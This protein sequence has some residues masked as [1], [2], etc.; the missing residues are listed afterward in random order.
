MEQWILA[1]PEMREFIGGRVMVA[2]PEQWMDRVDA[3]KALQGWDETSSVHFR[4][5]GVFGEQILLSIRYGAWSASTNPNR[6]SN[7]AAFW[8]PMIQGYVHAYRAATGVDLRAE[9]TD[10][11]VAG[12]RY[13]PPSVHLRNRLLAQGR[14]R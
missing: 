7:W 8:R 4:D 3:M 6:A 5:L 2:Y 1:R 14:V 9:L 10:A 12:D 11:R 13:L